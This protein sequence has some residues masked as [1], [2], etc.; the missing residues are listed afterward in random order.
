MSTGSPSSRWSRWRNRLGWLP[1][2]DVVIAVAMAA[3]CL[4]YVVTPG[5]FQGK[6]SG[7][8]WFGFNYLRAIFFHGTL[9]MKAALPEFLP[10]FGVSGPGHHMPNRCPFGPVIVWAPFYVVALGL[11]WLG[12]LVHLGGPGNGATP[13]EAAFTGLGTLAGVLVGWR[14]LYVLLERRFGRAAARVGSI[15]AIWGTPIVWYAVTQP[16]YQHGLAFCFVALLVERWDAWRAAPPSPWRFAVLGLLGGLAMTMRA[17]EVFYLLIPGVQALWHVARGGDRRRWLLSGV[18]LSV[19]AFVA[20]L[21]QLLVWRYYS[22]SMFTP[23]QVEPLRWREPFVIVSLFSTRGGLFPWS[24]IAYAATLGFVWLRRAPALAGALLGVF[25]LEIYLVSSAWVVT[26]GYG[27][28]AR[29]LS[30]SMAPVIALG[31]ALL[32]ARLASRLLARRLIVAFALLCVTLNVAAME[33][34]RAH[35][36]ASSG[37]YARPAEYMLNEELKAPRWLGRLFGTIGYPF[38]QPVGWLFALW[39]HVPV[40]TFEGL[41]GNFF[42]D[43]DGQWFQVQAHELPLG[44]NA[45]GYVVA[46]VDYAP[47]SLRVIGPMRLLLPLF[48]KEPIGVNLDATLSDPACGGCAAT[49]NGVSVPVRPQPGRVHLDVPVAP[50]RAGLNELRLT[51]P[52]GTQLT[53]ISFESFTQWWR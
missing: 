3:L 22:G 5:V 42:L 37:A 11:Q 8:G 7:D 38:V 49:W 28:G 17:Q 26:G 45:R 48:A 46:G 41:V 14:A 51:L 36:I 18:A 40:P 1:A 2:H 10:F 44:A 13:F 50:V 20:F 32:W 35:R 53:K 52:A 34:M 31:L 4:Y 19:A 27:Y 33:L 24:P 9:D 43:R 30:E 23:A 47:K 21:P 6:A 12:T 15:G 39:H 16:F 29:R 25:A